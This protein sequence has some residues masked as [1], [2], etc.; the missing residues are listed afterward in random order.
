M[1]MS[2]YDNTIYNRSKEREEA[3]VAGEQ[4]LYSLREARNELNKAR[5]WGIYDILGGGLISTF[6]KHSKVNKARDCIQRARY[7]L[8]NFSRELNDVADVSGC[9]FG[10]DG[11][12][13]FADYFFDDFISD[14]VV[15]SKIND[16][17]RKVD[18]II[19]RVS[20]VVEGLR[21]HTIG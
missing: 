4:A 8:K 14:L 6:I 1:D 9:D 13:G 15:Q 7:D 12:W 3:I 5:G 11:F 21:N 16:V 10:V 18:E 19:G 20:D 2:Y 17:R